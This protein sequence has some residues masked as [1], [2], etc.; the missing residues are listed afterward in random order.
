MGRRRTLGAGTA[1]AAM[2]VKVL[3]KFLRQSMMSRFDGSAKWER[4]GFFT[5]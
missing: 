5:C 2:G 4:N 3:R 1:A